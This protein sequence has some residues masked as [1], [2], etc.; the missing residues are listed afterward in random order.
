MPQGVQPAD[1]G[2]RDL[3]YGRTLRPDVEIS[4]R[5]I[6]DSPKYT[7]TAVGHHEGFS[8]SLVLLD[9]RITDDG[10]M[11]QLKRITGKIGKVLDL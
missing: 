3:V 5:P 6:P 11:A 7:A 10:K 9:T 2:K 1:Y 4:F 8:G